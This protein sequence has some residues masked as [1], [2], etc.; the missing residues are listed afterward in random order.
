MSKIRQE[1]TA[2]QIRVILSELFLKEV[3]DPRLEG[4]TVTEASIDR[5]LQHANVYVN[6]LGDESREK[7]VMDGLQSAS[8]FLRG[9]VA[10][11]LDLRSAP[12]LHFR[13]DPRLRYAEEINDLLDNLNI[14]PTESKPE[15]SPATEPADE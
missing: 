11:R 4:I 13:W 7:E 5:E 3:S 1:R 2:E 14:Q 9:Q 6:A 15:A 10:Q 12:I 8:G